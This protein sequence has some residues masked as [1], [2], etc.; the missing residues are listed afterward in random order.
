MC[1]IAEIVA[2]LLLGYGSYKD[3]KTREIPDYVWI[4][5][6]VCGILLRVADH[7]WKAL[8]LSVGVALLLGLILAVSGL[9]GG[10]DIKALVA[11]SVLIPYYPGVLLP[12]FVVSVFDNLAIIKVIEIPVV[13]F[14]NVVKGNTYK[15]DIVWWKK[16][17]LYMTGFPRQTETIDYR[18]L[19]LQDTQGELHLL[20]DVDMDIEQFKKACTLQ[21]VWVTYGSPLI[22]YLTIGCII[23]FVQ[24]D[25]LLQVMLRFVTG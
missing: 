23:A 17:L 5:M 24:G 12:V 15:G 1:M 6:G 4:V 18:F 19:P 25:I 20:P 21:E 2:V 22:V 7:Q 3:V 9:F 11:L 8:G 10:A 14:Y 13:L 16:I